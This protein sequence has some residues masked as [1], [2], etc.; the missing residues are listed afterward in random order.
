MSQDIATFTAAHFA[1]HTG[2]GWRVV[3]AGP[4]AA[5][6]PLADLSQPVDLEL[7]EVVP[8]NP[9]VAGRPTRTFSLL[10]RGPHGRHLPQRIYH[11]EHDRLGT[12]E[13]FLV[14]LTPDARGTLFEA[15]FN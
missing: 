1:P 15:V 13:L 12:L 5:A 11:L 10:F 9:A 6:G 2:G 14:P 7:I 3:G 8:A 4:N